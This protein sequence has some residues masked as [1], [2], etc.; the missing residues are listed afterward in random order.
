MAR[1][2]T[3]PLGEVLGRAD[4]TLGNVDVVLARVD[5]TL[6]D[7]SGTLGDAAAVLADVRDLLITLHE[8]LQLLDE[9]PVLAKQIAEI[10][11]AVYGGHS[12]AK[13]PGA[14]PAKSPRG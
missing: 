9:V 13:R 14:K 12:P 7:V 10:H 5:E 8:R 2:L 4:T 6:G 1:L 3:N 11:A